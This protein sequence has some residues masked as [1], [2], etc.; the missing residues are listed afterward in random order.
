LEIGMA[1]ELSGFPP[2]T[3]YA[4]R[5]PPPGVLAQRGARVTRAV[6]RRLSPYLVKRASGSTVS[7]AE[8]ARPLR[9]VC[10]EAGATFL[11]FGQIVASSPSL[12]GDEMAAEFRS[13]LDTGP[14]VSFER[15]LAE[16]EAGTPTTTSWPFARIDPEPLG[17]ASLAVVHRAQLRDGRDV[18][19]KVLR[20]GIERKVAADLTLMRQLFRG[21]SRAVGPGLSG[22]LLEVL[23]GLRRQLEEE[24]DLRNEA[25]VMRY[26]RALPESVQLSSVIVPEPHVDVS[27]RR[28]LVMEYLDG[29]PIDD[30]SAIAELGYDPAPVVDEVVKAWFT[31]ALRGG[32]FHGD[33]HAGNI[34]LLRDGRVG[35]IDWGIVGRLSPDSHFLLRRFIAASLGEETAWDDIVEF[36]MGQLRSMGEG[37]IAMDEETLRALLRQYVGSI[38]T[39][40]FGEVSLSEVVI[41]IQR[42]VDQVQTGGAPAPASVRERLDRLR[43]IGPSAAVMDRS[44]MLLA[45]QLAYFER[46]G[47]LYMGDVSLLHDREFFAGVLDAGPL[48]AS[49]T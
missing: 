28:V 20:P 24:L 42:A 33:V 15:V 37:A 9:K 34:L 17:R 8:L 47:K 19:V 32:I 39:R 40:P 35:V 5:T 16:L 1:V 4:L 12:F 44:M 7:A 36:L 22:L 13:C 31:T 11:K 38:V 25:A 23:S 21:L 46:Y 3:P 18:A 30:L 14:R 6:A 49:A 43:D 2:P 27:G 48:N 29:V 41:G 26:F 45:K 10:D